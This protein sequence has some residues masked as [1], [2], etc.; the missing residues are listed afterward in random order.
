MEDEFEAVVAGHVCLDITPEFSDDHRSLREI[1]VPGRLINIGAAK[2]STGGAVS[3]T[4]IPLSLMGIR[5]RLIGKIGRDLFGQGVREV[6]HRYGVENGLLE[7]EGEHTSYTVVIATPGYDRIFLHDPGANNTF[8]TNDIGENVFNNTRLF[9]FGYPPI[10]RRTYLDGGLELVKLFKTAK[11]KNVSTSLDMCMPDASAESGRVNWEAILQ[12]TLPYVDIFAPS[13][14]E[15]LFMLQ[16]DEYER[17]S[18]TASETDPLAG[19][20]MDMLADLSGRLLEYGAKIVLL[21]CGTKGLYIRTGSKTDLAGMGKAAPTQLDNWSNRELFEEIY[22]VPHVVSATGAGDCCIAG[23][24]AAL[25]RGKT[26][27]NSLRIAC[28]AGALNVQTYD[29]H[30]GMRPLNEIEQLI[31]EG[32][33]KEESRV[34]EGYFQ[35]NRAEKHWVGLNNRPAV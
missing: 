8:A 11:E 16:R 10:V 19:F 1:F 17:L 15:I 33:E 14:E 22:H 32:W 27:E 5:V 6:F 28:A 25:L 20:K 3:N 7:A 9:H 35:Y 2:I 23:F 31:A 24:L 18:Q 29:S 26:I 12:R 13:I 4:G 30:S 34:T 21:K